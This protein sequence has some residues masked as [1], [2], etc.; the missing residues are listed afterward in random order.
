MSSSID[1]SRFFA[2][3]GSA[4]F[5]SKFPVDRGERDRRIVADD[6]ARDLDGDL[7]DHRVHLARHDRRARLEVG[8]PDLAEAACGPEFI[9]RRSLRDLDQRNGDGLERAGHL[10]GRVHRALRSEVVLGFLQLEA[11]SL[12]AT[13]AITFDA[14]ARVGVQAGADGRAAEREL[15][16]PRRAASMRS[17]P[18][19]I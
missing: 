17:M 11:R 9:Q 6:L 14:N 18:S 19:S 1:S 16:E 3:T 2:I 15:A 5:S 7:G 12:A 13:F 8:E 4:T 10:H